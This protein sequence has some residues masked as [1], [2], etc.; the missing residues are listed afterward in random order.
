MKSKVKKVA[1]VGTSVAVIYGSWVVLKWTVGVLA[2][3]YTCGT[4]VAIVA[5]SP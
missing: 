3:P 2:A 4:S 1:K 5:V